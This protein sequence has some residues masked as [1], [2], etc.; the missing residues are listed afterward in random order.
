MGRAVR[1]CNDRTGEDDARQQMADSLAR[2]QRIHAVYLSAA[3]RL[4][5][6]AE[7]TVWPLM[8]DDVAGYAA[9]S[10]APLG[11]WEAVRLCAE[12]RGEVERLQRLGATIHQVHRLLH[13]TGPA[14]ER[15]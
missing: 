12:I 10:G 8:H 14:P 4:L 15:G 13:D 2:L 11:H 3:E 9:P 5:A 6:R 7:A 1:L